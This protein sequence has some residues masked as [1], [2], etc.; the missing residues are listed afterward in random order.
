M[1]SC[2]EYFTF[3]SDLIF[4]VQILQKNLTTLSYD[5]LPKPTCVMLGLSEL[6][7]LKSF[8]EK[9]AG[10][11]SHNFISQRLQIVISCRYRVRVK[12]LSQQ[13]RFIVDR[14]AFVESRRSW[15]PRS[16]DNEHRQVAF[17]YRTVLQTITTTYFVACRFHIDS[18]WY[19]FLG[20]W[21][22]QIADNRDTKMIFSLIYLFRYIQPSKPSKK[23]LQ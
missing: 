16:R 4:F 1:K 9:V 21:Y 2:M 22:I 17:A 10:R 3:S 11:F 8:I 12:L 15:R 20:L 19:N 6:V 5:N 23:R 7:H 18:V 14:V 13:W